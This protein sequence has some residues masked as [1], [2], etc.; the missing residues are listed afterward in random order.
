MPKPRPE[1]QQEY[2]RLRKYRKYKE[3]KEAVAGTIIDNKRDLYLTRSTPEH[4]IS[5]G[6]HSYL[7]L[8]TV[9]YLTVPYFI[10]QRIPRIFSYRGRA[11]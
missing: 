7:L 5:Y 6:I 2:K 11:L 8:S 9:Q 1:S 10:A 4:F 3:G